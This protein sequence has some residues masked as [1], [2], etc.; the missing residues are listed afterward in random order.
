MYCSRCGV[1]IEIKDG[2][3]MRCQYCGRDVCEMCC[4]PFHPGVRTCSDCI[5]LIEH[6]QTIFDEEV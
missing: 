4:E 3:S 6:D 5:H 2:E 1:S